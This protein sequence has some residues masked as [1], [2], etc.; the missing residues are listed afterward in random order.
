MHGFNRQPADL[1]KRVGGVA[2][3]LM[4]WVALPGCSNKDKAASTDNSQIVAQVNDSEIS[5]HQVQTMMQL[6]PALSNQLGEAAAGKV[7]D[8]LIEQ[9]LAAQAAR[10]AGLDT[11]PKVL[12]AME[13]AKREV[14]ARAYQDQLADKVVLPDATTVDRY[15]D[16]HPELF[17]KRRR[18]ALQE[19]VIQASPEQAKPLLDKLATTASVEAVNKLVADTGLPHSSRNSVQWAEGLPMDLLP[20]LSALQN[21]QSI[22]AYRPDGLVVLTLLRSEESP[23]TQGVASRAIQTAIVANK[24][25]ELIKQ[26]MDALRQSAK[27]QRKGA[28]APAAALAASAPADAAASAP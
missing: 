6:Q 28:F 4:M 14:L 15:Y 10:K 11:T 23:V 19:T 18:Y 24:R 25:R 12:Q 16:A 27:I 1:V 17:A 26:G 7:L 8:S 5:I 20:R 22:T 21:G 13:L 9:E 3:G 2:V